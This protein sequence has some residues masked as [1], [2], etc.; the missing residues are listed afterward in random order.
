MQAFDLTEMAGLV[1]MNFATAKNW[2]VGRPFTIPA[3]AYQASGRGSINLYSIDDVY[4]MAVAHEFSKAGFAANAI[5]KLVESLLAK[6]PS[7]GGAPALAVWRPKPGGKFEIREATN[8][9]PDAALWITINTPSIVGTINERA[10]K[11][12]KRK[13]K[14]R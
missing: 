4:L 5:G 2:T 8:R 12:A 14:K 9:A 7:L 1:G 13:A 3:S 6:Y 11:P 10:A